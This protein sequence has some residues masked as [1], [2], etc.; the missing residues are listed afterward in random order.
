MDKESKIKKL[1][2]LQKIDACVWVVFFV[3]GIPIYIYEEYIDN[4]NNDNYVGIVLYLLLGFILASTMI[5]FIILDYKI[6]KLKEEDEK[7][8]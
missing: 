7:K 2:K 8:A 4:S 6:K 3:T 1:D 5:I